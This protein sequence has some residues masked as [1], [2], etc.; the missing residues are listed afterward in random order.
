LLPPTFSTVACERCKCCSLFTNCRFAYFSL[1][2]SG[3]PYL[4]RERFIASLDSAK[5]SFIDGKNHA[6]T[7]R[8]VWCLYQTETTSNNSN[9]PF[10]TRFLFVVFVK[11]TSTN[12]NSFWVWIVY[13]SLFL[14]VPLHVGI[15]MRPISC[16]LT[17]EIC[18]PLLPMNLFL[19][20]AFLLLL[21][22]N[23]IPV[24]AVRVS[25]K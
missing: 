22:C 11:N 17:L 14:H 1:V 2:K 5:R 15:N 12:P 8:R 20:F 21:L 10:L 3:H 13:S 19:R 7:L 4:Y 25:C 23:S 18:S 6:L 16:C 24:P 9:T